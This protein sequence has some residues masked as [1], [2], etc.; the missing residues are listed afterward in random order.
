MELVGLRVKRHAF[1]AAALP[2]VPAE[3]VVQALKQFANDADVAHVGPVAVM[4]GLLLP[5]APPPDFM[6]ALSMVAFP[7]VVFY[8]NLSVHG[9][10]GRAPVSRGGPT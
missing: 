10:M 3:D 6:R 8:F 1:A 5:T 9:R 7:V 4:V 2:E